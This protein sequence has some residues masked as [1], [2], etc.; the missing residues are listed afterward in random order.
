[1]K[2]NEPINISDEQLADLLVQFFRENPSSLAN[3]WNRFNTTRIIKKQLIK[4]GKFKLMPRG[5]TKK[6][7]IAKLPAPKI[8][9]ED[10]EPD[11]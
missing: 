5:I 8:K 1:M 3:Y 7:V 2:I 9:I 10:N 6:K 4:L 11:W